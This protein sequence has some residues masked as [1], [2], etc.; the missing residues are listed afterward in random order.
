MTATRRRLLVYSAPVAV[1]VVLVVLKCV[2]V[3]L[4]GNSAVSSFERRDAAALS[5][6]A[7]ILSVLNVI[8]PARA[9]FAAGAQAVLEDRLEDAERSFADALA[10]TPATADCPV[11]VNLVLVQESRGDRAGWAR[12]DRAATA[13]YSQAREVAEQAPPGCFAD[14][15]DPDPQR[16][17]VR[18]DT[19]P[20]LE[21]KLRTVAVPLVPPPVPPPP[22]PAGGSAGAGGAEENAPSERRLHPESGDPLDRLQQ[23]LR[24]GAYR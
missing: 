7:R 4:A 10:H 8:E 23:I 24:D 13:L 20:R 12:D 21:A 2:S 19:L 11:R 1:L 17:A 18:H 15:A 3:V 9:H 5:T 16:R 22:P 6:D 14:N